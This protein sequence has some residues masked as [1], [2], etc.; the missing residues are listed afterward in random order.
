MVDHAGK[1]VMLQKNRDGSRT[2]SAKERHGKTYPVIDI[3]SRELLALFDGMD[4]VRVVVGDDKVVLLPLASE[5][6]KRE[7]ITRLV[8][9]LQAGEPLK[10]GSLAHGGG[11][12]THAVHQGLQDAGIEADLAFANEIR[13]DLLLHAI[14]HNDAWGEK[15]AAI[16][17]PM[18]EIAGGD[19]WLLGQL[20]KLEVLEVG[21]PCS[22]ASKAGKAKRGAGL[23]ESHPEVGHLVF[24]TLVIIAKTQ[25]AAV[26]I[27]CVPEYA[28]SASAAILRTQLLDMGY[29]SHERILQGRD[30]GSL[31]NRIRWCCV[32]VTQG[33]EFDFE[34]LEP[35]VRE[36][37]TLS[38]ILDPSIGPD[39]PMWRAVEYLK[40]K[41]E[42]D[43]AKG[44]RFLM[45]FV[46]PSDP[47]VPTIRKSYWKGGSTDPRL[48][49][50]SDPELSRLL[51]HEEVARVKGVDALLIEGLSR[52]QAIELLGQAIVYEP[53]RAAAQRLGEALLKAADSAV[54]LDMG[55]SQVARRR[56][57][58]TG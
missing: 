1:R 28:L 36:V 45:Q 22:G 57:R 53:F 33:V 18:Q 31:E 19:E 6:K 46:E 30:F 5:I 13:E 55:G 50:P 43:A 32:A 21:Q 42:R 24:S 56:E 48:R 35:A 25:P 39:H 47:E 11:I 14:E 38:D 26:L 12:L 37:K 15:T 17:V 34:Q 27:E 40:A 41:R 3:N 49:H 7:R 9:K 8:G 2:V 4:A 20:G 29:V 54:E 23:T 58:M 52:T 44:S 10:I 51:T 16:N